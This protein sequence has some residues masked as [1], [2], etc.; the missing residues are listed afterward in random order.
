[1]LRGVS[2][3]SEVP[4]KTSFKGSGHVTEWIKFLVGKSRCRLHLSHGNPILPVLDGGLT[5]EFCTG[6]DL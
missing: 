4:S 5:L 1:M 3:V 6:P 2:D